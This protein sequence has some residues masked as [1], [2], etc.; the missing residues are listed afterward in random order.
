[1]TDFTIYSSRGEVVYPSNATPEESAVTLI[2]QCISQDP[3]VD[4]ILDGTTIYHRFHADTGREQDNYARLDPEEDQNPF[5]TL[6]NAMRQFWAAGPGQTVR[7][8]VEPNWPGWIDTIASV[9]GE[10]PTAIDRDQFKRAISRSISSTPEFGGPTREEV[11]KAAKAVYSPNR[12]IAIGEHVDAS[13]VDADILFQYGDAYDSLEPLNESARKIRSTATKGKTG[14]SA[15][16][17]SAGR[18]L[19]LGLSQAPELVA[20]VPD[21]TRAAAASP[22][23][24]DYI[25]QFAGTITALSDM[26]EA[27][28]TLQLRLLRDL[29][30]AIRHRRRPKPL[31][32]TGDIRSDATGGAKESVSVDG[33]RPSA[34]ADNQSRTTEGNS[35]IQHRFQHEADRY[36]GTQD[37][38]PEEVAKNP[39]QQVDQSTRVLSADTGVASGADSKSDWIEETLALVEQFDD[40]R[41]EYESDRDLSRYDRVRI[42]RAVKQELTSQNERIEQ[43]L[44]SQQV[45]MLREEVTELSE[46]T[47]ASKADIRR[48]IS[49]RLLTRRDRFRRSPVAS[50]GGFLVGLWLF[51]GLLTLG[52]A[53]TLMQSS[54]ASIGQI[55]WESTAE[56]LR[57]LPLGS[58]HV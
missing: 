32:K 34:S 31:R 52:L 46:A 53:W 25:D 37:D 30:I 58:F 42:R 17:S 11:L 6:S 39:P 45:T 15:R 51:V 27:P 5:A 21:R 47:G 2:K 1:M 9:E 22:N 26:Q 50:A 8:P 35:P 12:R 57:L 14:L 33:G 24:R 18:T 7:E 43:Q 56:I 19:V 29:E 36:R 28:L 44:F 3:R 13:T 4:V 20:R 40:L 23:R 38:T 48:E 10:L 41:T 54:D 16:I 55:L 49:G